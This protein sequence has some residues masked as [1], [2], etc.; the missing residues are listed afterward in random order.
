LQQITN[1]KEYFDT[2]FDNFTPDT[3]VEFGTGDGEF[4]AM[5]RGMGDFM[6]HTFDIVDCPTKTEGVVYHVMNIFENELIVSGLLKYGRVLLLCDNGNKPREVNTFAKYLKSGDV[7]MA[8]DYA[9]DVESFRA[10]QVN[11]YWDWLEIVYKDVEQSLIEFTPFL[12]DQMIKSG[13][14]SFRKVKNDL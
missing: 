7:I 2:L 4:T 11:N 13:W 1:I 3:I 5:L 6:I 10:N 12:H 14:M 9:D 8:H